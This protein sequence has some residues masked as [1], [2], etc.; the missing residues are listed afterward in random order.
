LRIASQLLRLS[1]LLSWLPVELVSLALRK[2][3]GRPPPP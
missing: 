1:V 2:A 3:R